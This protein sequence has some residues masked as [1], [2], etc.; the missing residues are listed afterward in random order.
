M[1]RLAREYGRLMLCCI[2][3]LVYSLLA[4][5]SSD[6]LHTGRDCLKH[7]NIARHTAGDP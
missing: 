7:P 4:S 6:V 3:A 1:E 2:E 5:G